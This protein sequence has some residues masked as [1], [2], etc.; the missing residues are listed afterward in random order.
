MQGDIRRDVG[1]MMT[2]R[3]SVNEEGDVGLAC[4]SAFVVL[5]ALSS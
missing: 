1:R 3:V 2:L 4:A 5:V